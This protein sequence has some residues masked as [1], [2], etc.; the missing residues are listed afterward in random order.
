M[1]QFPERPEDILALGVLFFD[2]GLQEKMDM[3]GH[4]AGR[5]ELVAVAVKVS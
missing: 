4:N 1:H 2:P 3:V 5:E